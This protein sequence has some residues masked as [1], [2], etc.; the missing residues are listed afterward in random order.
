VGEDGELSFAGLHDSFLNVPMD[1]LLSAFKKVLASLYNTE[2]LE[3]RRQMNLFH[4]EMA[5]PVLYQLMIP[6][7]VAGV[8][9]TLDPNKPEGSESVLSG[10]WGLG[11]VVV[12][13]ES[14]AD[15]FR[16]SRMP[17]Y[18][19]VDQAIQEKQWM[20]VPME[21]GP[22]KPV[23]KSR[24]N[25]PCLTPQEAALIVRT[26]LILERYFKRPMDIEWSL[27]DKGRLW[28]LQARPIKLSG[29]RKRKG[30]IIERA[31]KG[32]RIL[33]KDRGIIAYRGVGAGP[34][35]LV[36]SSDDLSKFPTGA[37]LVS[38]Y[39]TPWLAKVISQA[40]AIV[41]D[42]GTITGHMATVAREF[43]VPTIVGTEVATQ[44]LVPNK[45]VTVDAERNV[46]YEGYIEELLHHQFLE[47]P[48]F[49][50][51]PEFQLLRRLLRKISPLYL[52]DPQAPNFTPKGCRTYHDIMRFMHEKAF[53]TLVQIGSDPR[54]FLRRGGKRL[55]TDIPLDLLIIDIGGGVA[56]KTPGETYITPDQITSVPMKAIWEGLSS[57][58]TWNI[59]PIPV[60]F[61]SLMS[62][63]TRTQS[64]EIMG[65]NLPGV[66]LAIIGSDYVNLSMPLGYHFTA[67]ESS[68]GSTPENNYIS[69]RFAGGVTEITRRSR[70]A[71]LL[72][73][74][75]EQA[76]FKVQINGD[77]VTA[78]AIDLTEEQLIDDLRLI[79]K[80]IGF[81]RQLDVM[82]KSDTD[83]DR[84]FEKFLNQVKRTNIN[85]PIE[86]RR[87]N[88]EKDNSLYS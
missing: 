28:I 84:Y 10:S 64:E 27:D 37:V 40:S 52:T 67:V 85:Q 12:E 33:L 55:R 31:I 80:L 18:P 4:M 70:R 3:Y 15:T 25:T 71:V 51:T 32:H 26:G 19:V 41:T 68:I 6:S 54:S 39:A 86:K 48:Q 59:E 72:M 11:K 53:E 62:S 58:E 81:T 65:N 45:V 30:Q 56:E 63:L 79:G 29:K 2:S 5:M 36:N 60:D 24:R 76:N 13:G 20:H 8:L 74:L 57:P 50:I 42:I 75:L 17:P 22:A 23:P 34:V 47:E 82:L 1:E 77:L 14:T 38:R 21:R 87:D 44:V 88:N 83:I 66:N 9:Y 43:R 16:V 78:R 46:I 35:F 49:E 61:K 69:F 7:R 73:K